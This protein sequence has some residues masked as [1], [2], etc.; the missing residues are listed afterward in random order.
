[1]EISI[2][3]KAHQTIKTK[4]HKGSNINTIAKTN[5]GGS[6]TYKTTIKAKVHKKK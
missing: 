6:G 4:V 2:M 3:A 1:M 5:L